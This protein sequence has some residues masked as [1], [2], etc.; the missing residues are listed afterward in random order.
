[1]EKKSTDDLRQELMDQPDLDA[2]IHENREFFDDAEML[3][4][5]TQLYDRRSISKAD[6]AR[7]SCISEV[8]LHQVFS[9]RRRPSRDRLLCICFGLEAT[10][11]EAQDL[12]RRA[13]YAQLYP[14]IK[15]EAIIAHGI[16]HH[17][18][19]RRINE[20]LFEENEKTLF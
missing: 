12:L 9:G 3:E 19:L 8:Y 6:L 4:M 13:R 18:G 17:T 11:E 15:R 16:V 20:E 10:L 14:R 7:N 2:Y 1:M 5:L